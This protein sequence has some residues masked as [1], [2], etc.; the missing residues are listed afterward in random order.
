[1]EEITSAN[2]DQEVINNELPVLLDFGAAW[3]GPCKTLDPILEKIAQSFAGQLLFG[4]V[5]VGAQPELAARYGVLGVPTLILLFQGNVLK[6]LS[7]VPSK[8]KIV[9]MIE[10]AIAEAGN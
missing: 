4:H 9:G 7:G 3:C 8:G 6:Q 10:D 1:M 2:F 5:D